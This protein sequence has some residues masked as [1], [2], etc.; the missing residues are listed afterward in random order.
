MFPLLSI[1]GLPPLSA[2]LAG[3]VELVLSKHAN[4]GQSQ[5]PTRTIGDV[6]TGTDYP[7]PREPLPVAP[8]PFANPLHDDIESD[9]DENGNDTH[10]TIGIGAIHPRFDSLH[11]RIDSDRNKLDA[12]LASPSSKKGEQPESPTT[13]P[14]SPPPLHPKT[15]NIVPS[16]SAFPPSSAK[17][18]REVL[19]VDDDY[20]TRTLMTRLLS[21]LG[22]TVHT[23]ENGQMALDI[24]SPSPTSVPS[25]TTSTSG[26][27]TSSGPGRQFLVVFM[28][29]Q[30]PIMSGLEAVSRLR[31]LGRHDFIVGVTGSSPPLPVLSNHEIHVNHRKCVAH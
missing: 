23:A 25:P 7:L 15:S 14:T 29:N 18:D 4:D 30:M 12:A 10:D 5:I 13:P 9:D 17:I 22:C 24:L 20:L 19:V 26:V 16:S 8:I 31:H 27:S 21:R 2:F 11:L 6:S 3:L 28:D 1:E